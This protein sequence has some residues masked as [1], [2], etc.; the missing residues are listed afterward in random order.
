[1][2]VNDRLYTQTL[3]PRREGDRYSVSSRLDGLAD[4]RQFWGRE[5][6]RFKRST[7]RRKESQVNFVPNKTHNIMKQYAKKYKQKVFTHN[8]RTVTVSRCTNL[9]SGFADI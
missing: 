1:M 2:Q 8:I 7:I 3:Y 5:M 9:L 4:G 6:C